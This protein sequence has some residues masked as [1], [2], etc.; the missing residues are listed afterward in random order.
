MTPSAPTPSD[1]HPTKQEL[2]ER[3]WEA[4][5]NAQATRFPGVKG[6]IPNF[7]GAEDAARRLIEIPEFQ[8]AEHI[9]CNPDSP[10]K[11]IRHLALKAGKV[12]YM[13][14]PKLR[15][16]QPFLCLDP[17]ALPVGSLW[18]AASIKGAGELGSPIAPEDLPPIDLVVTGCV[19]VSPQGARLGKGGGYSDL[20]YALLR[21]TER[22]TEETPIWSTVHQAQVV[23]NDVI[24]ML[25]HDF[26]LTGFVTPEEIVPCPPHFPRP[27]GID[28]EKLLPEKIAAIP[29]LQ[30]P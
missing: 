12:V 16:P 20:E 14:V 4:L 9:K 24:P 7:I 5:G 17:H 15:D 30:D 27:K 6:R 18:K 2:R 21:E 25:S 1:P 11:L 3:S 28:W 10:Q 26:P 22:I 13:A 8:A 29:I 19:A 23:E